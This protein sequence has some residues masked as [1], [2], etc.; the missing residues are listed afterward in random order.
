MLY[1][2]VVAIFAH[3]RSFDENPSE[4]VQD[5]HPLLAE[6]LVSASL[7]ARWARIAHG[8]S[9]A[10][11]P[12]FS[13]PEVFGTTSGRPL[14]VPLF[15]LPVRARWASL[16]PALMA[17]VLLFLDHVLSCGSSFKVRFGRKYQ[18]IDRT[19]EGC[20]VLFAKLRQLL[21]QVPLALLL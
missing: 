18:R 6:L 7:I 4:D 13:I 2:N 14:L 15:D 16:L 20:C 5:T 17:T 10:G 12:S 8:P 11:L 19:A 21:T 3:P 1:T 9:V